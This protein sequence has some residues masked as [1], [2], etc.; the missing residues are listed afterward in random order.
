MYDL[1]GR[2]ASPG[3]IIL[4]F[5]DCTISHGIEHLRP[6]ERHC[7]K[8]RL[9]LASLDYLAPKEMPSKCRARIAFYVSE[10]ILKEIRLCFPVLPNGFRDE[11]VVEVTGDGCNLVLFKS[12]Y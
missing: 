8:R 7:S 3:T 2:T 11:T 10:A 5:K 6:S 1:I 12:I 4:R 9:I